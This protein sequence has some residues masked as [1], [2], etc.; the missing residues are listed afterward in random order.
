MLL[1]ETVFKTALS[2][3]AT[4]GQALFVFFL[5]AHW[6][7]LHCRKITNIHIFYTHGANLIYVKV[8]QITSLCDSLHL[9]IIFRGITWI[10]QFC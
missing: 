7:A 4:G 6:L 5:S 9:S 1:C 10:L 8:L 3:D 2:L